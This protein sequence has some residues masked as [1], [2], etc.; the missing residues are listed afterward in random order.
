MRVTI[1][2]VPQAHWALSAVQLAVASGIT[3]GYPDGT[4]RGNLSV[5]RYQAVA[6]IARLMAQEDGRARLTPS[7]LET[8]EQALRELSAG[9]SAA[10][11]GSGAAARQAAALQEQVATLQG[12]VQAM[13]VQ[14]A[15]RDAEVTSLKRDLLAAD[16]RTAAVS[17]RL[18]DTVVRLQAQQDAQTSGLQRQLD[19]LKLASERAAVPPAPLP[20]PLPLPAPDRPF[21]A[22]LP[23]PQMGE[24][25]F[26]PLTTPV[27]SP[28]QPGQGPGSW[29][30]EGGVVLSCG[31]VLGGNLSLGRGGVLGPLGVKLS[32]GY[33]GGPASAVSAD[34]SATYDSN[35]LGLQPQVAL[36]L[37]FVVGPD[38]ASDPYVLGGAQVVFPT[39]DSFGLYADE[40]LR[41]FLGNATAAAGG[42]GLGFHVQAGVRLKF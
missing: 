33:L 11:T 15:S 19:D 38:A 5:T 28:V 25:R 32:A 8:L 30:L 34:V 31:L 7:Q 9:V 17:Q 27:G 29:H 35:L 2:D 12:Q 39:S 24:P 16:A 21:G 26:S 41:Y 22:T 42:G 6:M 18:D 1:R 23:L 20:V 4:F 10:Q 36:G 3:Q 37:G 13:Q 14:Q 40:Q